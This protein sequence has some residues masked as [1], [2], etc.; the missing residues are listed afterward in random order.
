[1]AAERAELNRLE[2]LRALRISNWEAVLATVHATLTGGVFQTGF[3][4]WLGANN[5]WMGVL[6]AIPT[7][8]GLVQLVSSYFVERR[9]E[10]RL[11]TAF[12]SV[13][14]RTLWLPI[15][16]LPW[17]L[18]AE[19]RFTAFVALFLLSSIL[20]SIPGPAFTSWMSDLVPPDHRGR[21]FGRRNMLAGITTML[22]SLPAGWFLDMAV[23]R[24]LF[25]EQVGFAALFVAAAVCG[26]AAFVC[27]LRQAEPPKPKAEPMAGGLRAAIAFYRAPFLDK[28]FRGFLVF[29]ALLAAAQ[30][31]AAPFFTVYA[32][33]DLSLNYATLQILGAISSLTALASLPLWGYLSDKF[34]NRPLLTIGVAGIS[35]LPL[36]WVFTNSNYPT[37]TLVVIFFIN[38][39]GGTFWAGVGLTQFNLLIAGT[40]NERKSVYIGAMA[41]VIG[42]AG[43]LSPI[44]GGLV[45]SA[46][47]DVHVAPLGW[48]MGAYQIVFAFNCLMRFAALFSLRWV[49]ERGSVSTAREVLTQVGAARVGGFMQVRKLQRGSS[50]TE[51]TEAAR[52]LSTAKT[53]MAVEELT[54][55]L[56]DPSLHVREEAVIAL[57]EIGDPRA[58]DALIAHLA[59]HASGIV[60][61]TAEALGRIGDSRA[62]PALVGLLRNAE[63]REQVAAARALGRIR[64]PQALA[65]LMSEVAQREPHRD[66]DVADWCVSAMGSI[67]HPAAV[68]VLVDCL[69]DESRS[70]RMAAARAIGDIGD[71]SA[72]EALISRLDS[73]QDPAVVSHLAVAL[74]MVGAA[75]A[76]PALLGA[77]ER[78]DSPIACKQ[79]LNAAGSL[80]GEA[81]EFYPALGADE[82]ARDEAVQRLV[83]EITRLA[84]PPPNSETGKGWAESTLGL[85]LEG[86]YAG[87]MKNLVAVAQNE[88][89][90]GGEAAAT[91]LKWAGEKAERSGLDSHELLL[92]LF[93]AR[94]LA[95]STP[96]QE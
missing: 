26:L 63:R 70:L 3:A 71:S 24:H 64:D 10:R 2:V 33:Q 15:L 37:A 53:A 89:S 39:L 69:G 47:K 31:F 50:E 43:G 76:M 9:G 78:T 94:R 49:G 21:Y 82:F 65:A 23:K 45:V 84:D 30:F 17:I 5:V 80:M 79:I 25:S 58:V 92:G 35:L 61:D 57:G 6:G 51:R 55:A 81:S 36:G 1:M 60:A 12:F 22:V 54:A 41:G 67:G 72:A 28:S 88:V 91:A 19:A 52:A 13:I 48:P 87:V 27:L 86:D 46:I 77:L 18:P 11:F 95:S 59:D 20:L 16:L 93:A 75:H 44:L 14:G 85:Y 83:E 56:D 73:E 68:Q 4:L 38:V 34:G 8:A 29:G 96:E 32:L 74:A 7:S 40:P 62:T 90:P 42:L 66:S